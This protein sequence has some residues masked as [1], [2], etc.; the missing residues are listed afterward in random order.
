MFRLAWHLEYVLER[1]TV[2]PIGHPQISRNDV[3]AVDDRVHPLFDAPVDDRLDPRANDLDLLVEP[4]DEGVVDQVGFHRFVGVETRPVQR[5]D[6]LRRH[7]ITHDLADRVG[8]DDPVD[9]E[10]VS[11]LDRERRLPDPGGATQQDEKR[12]LQLRQLSGHPVKL[13]LPV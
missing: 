3:D 4:V 1:V 6:Q 2:V 8:F 9:V 7:H 12:F 13:L 5:R 10:S 11:E